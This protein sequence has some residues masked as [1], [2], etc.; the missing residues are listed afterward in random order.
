MIRT[1]DQSVMKEGMLTAQETRLFIREVE[2]KCMKV[3]FI[4]LIEILSKYP[5]KNVN[6]EDYKDFISQAKVEHHFWHK[7]PLEVK[8]NAVQPFESR[9]IACSFGKTVKAFSVNF[10]KMK[11]NKLPGR[12]VY[13]KSFAL[14]FELK[15]NELIDFGWC[16][17]FLGEKEIIELK[18]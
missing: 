4:G 7:N 11:D 15:N 2:E 6:Q 14:N 18:N 3:D 9:C 5:L 17:A 16:N 10:L 13:V 12:L 8:I 1:K